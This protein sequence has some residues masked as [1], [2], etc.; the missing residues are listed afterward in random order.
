[1]TVAVA[2]SR[3][4]RRPGRNAPQRRDRDEPARRPPAQTLSAFVTCLGRSSRNSSVRLGLELELV[5]DLARG[6]HVRDAALV[7]RG[8]DD[9]LAGRVVQVDRDLAPERQ[10]DVGDGRR[11]RRREQQADV[12]ARAR[13]AAPGRAPAPGRGAASGRR[14]VAPVLSTIARPRPRAPVDERPRQR[15]PVFGQGVERPIRGRVGDFGR[16]RGGFQGHVAKAPSPLACRRHTL[17]QHSPSGNAGPTRPPDPPRRPRATARRSCGPVR[18]SGAPGS[19]RTSNPGAAPPGGAAASAARRP[20][21]YGWSTSPDRPRPCIGV[22]A[23]RLAPLGDD[24]RALAGRRG[25]LLDV[26]PGLHDRRRRRDLGDPQQPLGIDVLGIPAAPTASP[27]RS[28]GPWSPAPGRASRRRGLDQALGLSQGLLE[29]GLEV[30]IP[31]VRQP[32]QRPPELGPEQERDDQD[33][34]RPGQ[35]AGTR[36]LNSGR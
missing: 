34:D 36:V 11:D 9:R 17:R 35:V 24:P 29:V 23:G 21:A 13:A 28:P 26:V 30:V 8:V 31:H 2:S 16:S 12:T 10:G 15:R 19:T 6:D 25:G 32:V 27:P 7:D 3:S 18:R 22:A 1:M 20:P 14:S 4:P 33:R 5:E